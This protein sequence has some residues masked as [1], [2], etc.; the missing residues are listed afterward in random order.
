MLSI[1]SA[2]IA[3]TIGIV[4]MCQQNKNLQ[5]AYVDFWGR[6][7]FI[8]SSVE[9]MHKCE[10]SKVKFGLYKTLN[11]KTDTE[12]K[13]LKLPWNTCD[14]FDIKLFRRCFGK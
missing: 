8:D 5:I 3:N 1:Y 11:I 12:Q 9:D 2:A 6:Q 7:R 14:I 10:K 13:K 4:Y